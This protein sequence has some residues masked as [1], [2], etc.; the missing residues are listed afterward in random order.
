[1]ANIVNAILALD[2]NA[3]VKVVG[4]DYDKITWFDDNPN[5]ITVDQI[6]TKKAELDKVD[7]ANEYQM[8]RVKEYPRIEDQLDTIYHKGIDEWKKIIKAVKD[9][10]PKG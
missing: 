5:K 9:K 6:K 8:Q 2:S 4:E 7:K 10:Y 1:M 3:K